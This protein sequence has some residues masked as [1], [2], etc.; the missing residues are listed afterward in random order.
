MELV[1]GCRYVNKQIK[2]EVAIIQSIENEK[3]RTISPITSQRGVY[4]I[5]QFKYL[6]EAQ[7]AVPPRKL[8]LDDLNKLWIHKN[9]EICLQNNQVYVVR[10]LSNGSVVLISLTPDGQFE[11]IK[12]VNDFYDTFRE[13]TQED[14]DNLTKG[15]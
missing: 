8:K 12:K 10:I 7:K 1:I 15:N 14:I 3:V 9:Q 4:T 13:A 5:E 6:F 2:N 11:I